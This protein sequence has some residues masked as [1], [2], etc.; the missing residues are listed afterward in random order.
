MMFKEDFIEKYEFKIQFN[1]ENIQYLNY[2]LEQLKKFDNK[3]VNCKIKKAADKIDP[4]TQRITHLL[5]T[6]SSYWYFSSNKNR[7]QPKNSSGWAYVEDH[8]AMIHKSDFI[9]DNR[10]KYDKLK[11]I[12]IEKINYI[13]KRN[14]QYKLML[15]N[16][17]II[18]KKLS[19]LNDSALQVLSLIPSGLKKEFVDLDSLGEKWFINIR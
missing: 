9:E 13:E 18:L 17:D 10:L 12:I 7:Y 14:N 15:N 11:E 4:E 6:N 1:K 2:V 19:E 8:I 5:A 16:L 3:V